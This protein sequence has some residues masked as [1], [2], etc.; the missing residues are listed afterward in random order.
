[1]V[2]TGTDWAP[3]TII[4]AN[5]KYYARLKALKTTIDAIEKRL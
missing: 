3:W 1:M 5:S 2:R 4:E